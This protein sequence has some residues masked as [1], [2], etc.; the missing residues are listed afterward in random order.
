[1]AGLRAGVSTKNLPVHMKGPPFMEISKST[2][3]SASTQG[4]IQ[5]PM[6]LYIRFIH[7]LMTHQLLN[8]KKD[9][10]R[11]EGGGGQCS[12]AHILLKIFYQVYTK[13]E[14]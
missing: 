10:L 14:I 4:I 13:S 8:L 5:D 6:F 11:E 2:Q 9:T 7:F 1:M 12:T 3:P